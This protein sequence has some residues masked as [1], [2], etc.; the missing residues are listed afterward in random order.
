MAGKPSN[1]TRYVV[2][3]SD[4]DSFA[5]VGEA[6]ASSASGAIKQIVRS[7]GNYV[8]VPERSFQIVPVAVEIQ[9]PKF[10]IGSPDK[11]VTVATSQKP[12]LDGKVADAAREMREELELPLAEDAVRS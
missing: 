3:Q 11:E 7:A 8:A 12:P 9:E 4:G 10:V 6:E 2:L 1:T 5:K